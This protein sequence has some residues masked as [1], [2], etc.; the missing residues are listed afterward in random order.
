[1]YLS[2]QILIHDMLCQPNLQIVV[3]VFD[4]IN[5]ERSTTSSVISALSRCIYIYIHTLFYL[6]TRITASLRFSRH[7]RQSIARR[8]AHCIEL[9]MSLCFSVQIFFEIFSL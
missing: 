3:V 2:V 7:G 8:I 4:T 1:M 6:T 5:I 9:K